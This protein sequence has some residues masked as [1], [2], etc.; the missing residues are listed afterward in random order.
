LRIKYIKGIENAR[1]DILGKKLGYENKRKAKDF[2]VF[3]KNK[4][5]LIL[6]KKELD[7]I[8]YINS[9]LFTNKIKTTYD[10]NIIAE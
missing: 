7:S 5:N 8:I 2:V 10:S 6:N 9:N 4:N 1:A 3:R